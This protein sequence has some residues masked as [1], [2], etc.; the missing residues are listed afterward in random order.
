LHDG[1]KVEFVAY[2]EKA[3]QPH[4]L[5]TMVRLQV[6]KTHLDLLARQLFQVS[7]L[8]GTYRYLDVVAN[9]GGILVAELDAYSVPGPIA[10]AG[11]PGLI[12]ASG[13]LLAWWRRR[14]KIA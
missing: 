1:G 13:G 14:Q 10:G 8:L 5:E 9:A 11:L 6:R 12:L 7:G 3:P 4:T 2:T